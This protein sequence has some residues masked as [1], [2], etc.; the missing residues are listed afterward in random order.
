MP[1]LPKIH[2]GTG[3]VPDLLPP[4]EGKKAIVGVVAG[5]I[6]RTAAADRHLPPQPAAESRADSKK[7]RGQERVL[8][9]ERPLRALSSLRL[10][11]ETAA[12]VAAAP[13]SR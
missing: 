10:I 2:R 13:A 8:P 4:D 7:P 12:T 1:E 11:P 9:V 3:E 6:D 5:K